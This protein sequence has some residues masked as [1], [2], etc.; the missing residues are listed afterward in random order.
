MEHVL[1]DLMAALRGS[2]VRISPSET[3]DALRAASLVGF[4]ERGVLRDALSVALAKSRTE[5]EIFTDCFDRFFSPDGFMAPG[6]QSP[7]VPSAAAPD[8]LDSPLSRM[9]L[10]GDQAGLSMAMREAAEKSEIS[11]IFFFT[12]KSLFIQRILQGMGLEGLDRD[13]TRLSRED[14]KASQ[15]KG[16]TLKT[17]KAF[18]F[19]QVRDFVEQQYAVY[20]ASAR[21]AIMDRYLRDM[22]LSNLEER[23]Y[24]RM[25]RIIQ[26]MVKA[27]N[28]THSRRKRGARRGILD[29][30]KTLR[31]NIAYQGLIFAPRWKAKKIDRPDMVVLCDISRSVEAVSRFTLLF[32]YSLNDE[33][34]RIRS[35]VFCSNMAEVSH[36]FEAYGVDEALVRLQKGTG[37]GVGLGR[38][39]YGQTFR[40]LKNHGLERIGRRTTV[41]ILGDARNNY[42]APETGIL[43]LIHKRARRVIWLNPESPPFWGTGDSEMKRYLPFCTLARECSSV[44]HLE[45]VVGYLVRDG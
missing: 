35:F 10:S 11:G 25:H 14:R 31:E 43:S 15:Q 22:K 9:L 32:L 8:S 13:I 24:E 39:D 19:E 26:K 45:R 20:A 27:L 42:G 44:N 37:L 34:A 30:K 3:M 33:I 2:G 28:D 7:P 21:E 18:L 23:D 38:T 29:L 1:C 36:I 17:Q 5:K 6:A 16:G 12:Q 4:E 41:L 40:E